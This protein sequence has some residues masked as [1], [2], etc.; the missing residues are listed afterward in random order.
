MLLYCGQVNNPQSLSV[1]ELRSSFPI[2]GGKFRLGSYS[3]TSFLWVT[4]GSEWTE[5]NPAGTLLT[6]QVCTIPRDKG[7]FPLPTS[8]PF[9]IALQ[10]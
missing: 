5:L 4:Q 3:D 6:G 10:C 7:C 8:C 2:P 9:F 1:S